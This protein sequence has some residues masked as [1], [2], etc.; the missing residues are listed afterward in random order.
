MEKGYWVAEFAY[1]FKSFEF[2]LL[3]KCLA[4]FGYEPLLIFFLAWFIELL[5]GLLPTRPV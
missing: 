2:L 5:G 3:W 1:V 4:V